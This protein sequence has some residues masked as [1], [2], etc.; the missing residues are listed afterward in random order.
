MTQLRRAYTLLLS[1]QAVRQSALLTIGSTTT[2]VLS[3]IALI[4]VS[5]VLG[6]VQFGIFSV[7]TAIMMIVS[8]VGDMGLATIITR[9]LP[10][11]HD[12]PQKQKEFLAQ[13]SQWKLLLTIV[14][15]SLIG[16]TI[17]FAQDL[18]NYPYPTLLFLA[19]IGSIGLIIY[20]YVFL[21]LSAMHKF[22]WV[23]VLNV[24]QAAMKVITFVLL[25]ITG[26]ATATSISV[27]YY[28]APLVAALIVSTFFGQWFFILPHS[29]SQTLRAEVKKH[30]GHA[31]VGMIAATLIANIDVLFVQKYLST[32]ETG[33]YSASMRIALFITFVSSAVGGVLNN[34]VARYQT[35]QLLHSYLRKS[36]LIV[37]MAATGFLCFLPF[38]QYVLLF[39]LGP[40]FSSG[41]IP[42]IILVFNAFLSLAI[43]PLIS[44]FYAVDH[45]NYFSIGGILQVVVICLGNLFFL[46]SYGL[47]A[48]A[49]S[50]VAATA[51]HM[52]FT[53][54]YVRYA[55]QI[56]EKK[57]S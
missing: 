48:A 29:G 4:Y 55:L 36:L 6:P 18:L 32:F 57:E 43:V 17:P 3:A 37:L 25:G 34:R 14:G 51:L 28:A 11:L 12:D 39:T 13:I 26:Y 16:L 35:S 21:V 20:E 50:R 46:A 19:L 2:A 45:P 22:Q 41:L 15:I 5:R 10:R 38:A 27:F 53:V 56:V 44:F 47:M 54:W 24:L 52:A 9:Q 40:E 33:I 30:V 31:A 7:G 49:L 23:G 1:S 42:M 8:K